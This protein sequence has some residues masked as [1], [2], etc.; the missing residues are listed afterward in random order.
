MALLQINKIL[1]HWFNPSLNRT[2]SLQFQKQTLY[3]L[4]HLG[5]INFFWF[6]ILPPSEQIIMAK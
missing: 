1:S 5:G 2:P 3:P 4:G 6:T